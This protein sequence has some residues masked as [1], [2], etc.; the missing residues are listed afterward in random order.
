M[1]G[2]QWSAVGLVLYV[3]VAAAVAILVTVI[4]KAG[5]VQRDIAELQRVLQRESSDVR[6]EIDYRADRHDRDIE[7]LVSE[8]R[9]RR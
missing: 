2:D 7:M 1:T 3:V 5:D 6:R 4:F 8:V 9:R